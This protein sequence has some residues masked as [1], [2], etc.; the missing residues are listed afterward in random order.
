MLSGVGD[1]D[2]LRQV[3]VDV[4]AHVPGVGSNLQDHLEIYVVDKCKKPISL[5]RDQ[6]GVRMVKVGL[7][8]FYNQTGNSKWH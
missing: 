3:G 1:A 2:H 6:K 7:Q 5:L 8:W 4:V